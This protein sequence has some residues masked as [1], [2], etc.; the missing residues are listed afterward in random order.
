M[1]VEPKVREYFNTGRKKLVDVHAN[2]DYTLLLEY[3]NGEKRLYDLKPLDGVFACL[4]PMSIF[5]R[6]YIDDCGC[7]AW[8][9]DPAVDSNVVWDNKI[10]L[11]PDSCYLDSKRVDL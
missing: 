7:V 6:V 11:C 4:K 3:S 5:R 8:D 10:D 9:K 1:N 2:D